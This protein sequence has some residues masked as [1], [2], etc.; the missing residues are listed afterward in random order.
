[1]VWGAGQVAMFI[2]SYWLVSDYSD[3][4][5]TLTNA[6]YATLTDWNIGYIQSAAPISYWMKTGQY[7][8]M[9]NFLS[10]VMFSVRAVLGGKGKKLD[11]VYVA[12]L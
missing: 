2:E 12:T 8:L 1:M 3:F 7:G 11:G 9:F 6:N 5:W 10:I 4:A